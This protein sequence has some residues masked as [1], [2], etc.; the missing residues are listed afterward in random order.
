MG[1]AGFVAVI[2]GWVTTEVGRQPYTVYGLLRT[3][4]SASPL[5]APAVAASLAAFAV[6]YF[7]VFGSGV[8][9]LLRLMSQPPSSHEAELDTHSPIRAAGITPAAAIDPDRLLHNR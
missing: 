2:C 9:Y 1:P 5:E 3:S 8:F 7:T 6:V 4:H